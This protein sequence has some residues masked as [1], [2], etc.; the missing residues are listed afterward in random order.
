LKGVSVDTK[1]Q[2][3]EAARE[4]IGQKGFAGTRVS[5]IV[6]QAGVA[7]GTFYLYFKSKQDVVSEIANSIILSQTERIRAFEEVGSRITKEDFVGKIY[8]VFDS[9]MIFF[10]N[11]ADIMRVLAMEMDDGPTRNPIFAE[12]IS[13]I[14]KAFV[15][16]F[17]V[18]RNSGVIKDMDYESISQMAIMAVMQFFFSTITRSSDF[19]SGENIRH[20]VDMCLYGILK[21]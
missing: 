10:R 16:F 5:D 13:R 4:V 11:N 20:F 6:A 1:Q 7:Q 19:P 2:I 12:I 14:H 3:L 21:V 18:G 8:E 9:Y 15:H 17:E